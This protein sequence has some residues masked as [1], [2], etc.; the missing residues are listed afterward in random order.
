MLL[1]GF[2][3]QCCMGRRLA[4]PSRAV[5]PRTIAC[6]RVY[7]ARYLLSRYVLSVTAHHY[8][9]L[10]TSASNC[11]YRALACARRGILRSERRSR[12]FESLPCLVSLFFTQVLRLL[13][14]SY[15]SIANTTLT[16]TSTL[17]GE[18]RGPSATCTGDRVSLVA[19]LTSAH[20]ATLTRLSLSSSRRTYLLMCYDCVSTCASD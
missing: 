6:V 15:S 19:I 16:A 1:S 7:M 8:A 12:R 2:R 10:F 17:C 11:L 18:R 13:T 4:A 14:L 3:H 9:K 5:A 20:R